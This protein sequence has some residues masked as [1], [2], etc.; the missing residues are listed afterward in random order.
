MTP[1]C[2]TGDG[3]EHESH[4]SVHG[5]VRTFV[6]CFAGSRSGHTNIRLSGALD[7]RADTYTM[8]AASNA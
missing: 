6:T 7:A 3:E 2:K 5:I 1:T 8:M 4:V